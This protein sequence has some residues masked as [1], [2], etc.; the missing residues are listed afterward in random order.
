[1]APPKG[2]S[3]NP[4]G[5]RKGVPNKATTEFKEHLNNLLEKS[6]P[7]MLKWLEE[8]AE[9]DPVKAFDVLA[10]FA[11]F[12][13][14]KLLRQETRLTDEDGKDRDLNIT[15]EKIIHRAEDKS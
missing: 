14:P 5:R 8:I 1:M 3:N 4:G 12:I 7:K 13:H 6:A 10:K 9:E 15:I 11:E 2:K